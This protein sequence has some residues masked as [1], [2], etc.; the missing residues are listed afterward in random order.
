MKL[1][2]WTHQLHVSFEK[3]I[4]LLDSEPCL[5][6]HAT[7]DFTSNSVSIL[8]NLLCCLDCTMLLL[9][10]NL[11]GELI[12]CY[13]GIKNDNIYPRLEFCPLGHQCLYSSSSSC[14][15]GQAYLV[16]WYGVPKLILFLCQM[17]EVLKSF[18]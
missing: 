1:K 10:D 2:V 12:C 17:I 18:V 11:N 5:L 7:E 13:C 15:M 3:S 4:I 16:I 6:M 9:T 14:E 8:T